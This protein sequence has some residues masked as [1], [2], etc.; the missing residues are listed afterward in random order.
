MKKNIK[1]KIN[2][3]N[4]TNVDKYFVGFGLSLVVTILLNAVILLFK[5][6]S[7]NVM[8]AMKAALGHHWT[9]HG[10]ILIVV[11]VVLGFIL[12]NVK[13]KTKWDSQRMLKY[14][15]WAVIISTAIIAGFFLPN[16]KI[17]SAIKY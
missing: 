4:K 9:T 1:K 8:N 14:I 13:L 15:I 7:T 2:I 5:E 3:K 12:S 16:L 17:A 10:V 11:F 6:I